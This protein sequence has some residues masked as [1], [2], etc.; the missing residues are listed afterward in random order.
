MGSEAGK[1]CASNVDS[2][3]KK[4]CPFEVNKITDNQSEAVLQDRLSTR[5]GQ[6]VRPPERLQ[7][8]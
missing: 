3:Y 1:I 6:I 2:S 4:L 5:P 7:V 8:S